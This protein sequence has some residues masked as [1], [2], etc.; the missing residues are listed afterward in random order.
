[1]LSQS[2]VVV[3]QNITS[4]QP[5]VGL[6]VGLFIKQIL[7]FY[8]NLYWARGR[9]VAHQFILGQR[10]QSGPSI[11]IKTKGR[12]AAHQFILRPKAAKRPI[13]LY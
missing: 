9:K 10:P 6:L 13:N 1:M 2:L 12:K 8:I 3:F 5:F 11:Y 4:I 7:L